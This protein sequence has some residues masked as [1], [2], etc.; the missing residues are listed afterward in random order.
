MP[1]VHRRREVSEV[2]SEGG[3]LRRPS[4]GRQ[5]VTIGVTAGAR[6]V[7]TR[8]VSPLGTAA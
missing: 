1:S 3:C 5:G 4:Q 2:R 7:K 6:P 8:S